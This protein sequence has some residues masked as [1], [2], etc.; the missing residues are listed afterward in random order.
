MNINGLQNMSRN[1]S[2]KLFWGVFIPLLFVAGLFWLDELPMYRSEMSILALP[3]TGVAIGAANN[4]V[5]L[6]QE[7][8]FVSTLSL[9]NETAV[10]S[11]VGKAGI[12]KKFMW[13]DTVDIRTVGRSDVIRIASVGNSQIEALGRTRATA[14]EIVR[15]A[16]RYYNQKTD[17]EIRIVGEATVRLNMTVWPYFILYSLVTAL[18]FTTLFFVVHSVVERLSSPMRWQHSGPGEYIIT[19]ETFKPRIPAYWGGEDQ[20]SPSERPLSES[21]SQT[22][23][24]EV[25][26]GGVQFHDWPDGADG[27]VDATTEDAIVPEEWDTLSFSDGESPDESAGVNSVERV[28][29]AE[30]PDNLPIV[31]RP[32]TPLQGAQARLM[33]MDIDAT[34]AA[35]EA[36]SE[37]ILE[38]VKEEVKPQTHEPTP[39]EYRRRLNELLSGKM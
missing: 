5:A 26:E 29:Q 9:A 12:E 20:S 33:K 18:L 27:P 35:H 34:A 32:L 31:D 14:V 13:P 38:E 24:A 22:K 21:D 11:R 1:F 3:K 10:G 19:P 28:V 2:V 6:A 25:I 36:F 17:L 8:S 16:S 30:A 15:I 37:S 23:T 7:V 39:E 4:L